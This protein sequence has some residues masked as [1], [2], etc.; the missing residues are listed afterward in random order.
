MKSAAPGRS[1]SRVEVT[2]VSTH[3]FWN[4]IG[5]QELFAPFQEFPWFKRRL[6]R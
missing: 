2:N 1:T 6:Y 5:A 4:L 3:G